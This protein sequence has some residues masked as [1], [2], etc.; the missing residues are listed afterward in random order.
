MRF[1]KTLIRGR[2]YK[3]RIAVQTIDRIENIAQLPEEKGSYV[4]EL[5]DMCLRDFKAKKAYVS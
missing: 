4:F 3:L 5:I 1:A 2:H